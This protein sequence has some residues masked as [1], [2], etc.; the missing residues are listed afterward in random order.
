MKI[1]EVYIYGYGKLS[2]LQLPFSTS[3]QV[4]YG[5]NEAGKSTLMSFIHGILFGFPTKQQSE[6][7]YEPKMGSKYGG[8]MI[9]EIEDHGD[10][11]IERVAG[12][13]VGNVTVKLPDGTIGG[14]EL[15]KNLLKNMNKTMYKNIFSFNVHGLQGVSRLKGDDIGR[16]LLAAGTIGTETIVKSEEQLQKEMD[17]LFKPNGRKPEINEMLQ[18]LKEHEKDF[19]KSMQHNQMYESLQLE[20]QKLLQEINEIQNKISDSYTEVRKLEQLKQDWSLIQERNQILQRIEEIGIPQFPIDGINRMEKIEDQ[21]RIAANQLQILDIRKNQYEKERSQV[22]PNKIMK[23]YE[24]NIQLLIEKWPKIFQWQEEIV[25]GN[26]ELT[27]W[28]D[29]ISILKRQIHFG[30]SDIIELSSLDLSIDMK[31]RIRSSIKNYFYLTSQAAELNKQI[32]IEKR[33]QIELEKQC[34]TIES[35]LL[36]EDEFR[37]LS[38]NQQNYTRLHN[39]YHQLQEQ[40]KLIKPE[41]SSE[42]KENILTYLVLYALFIGFLAWSFIT[43]HYFFL[44]SAFVG[45]VVLSYSIWT[46]KKKGKNNKENQED[47]ILKNA[48]KILEEIKQYKDMGPI[49]E[50]QQML[51]QKWKEL[52]L[53]IENQHVRSEEKIKEHKVWEVEWESVERKLV[54]IKQQLRLHEGFSVEQLPDA[55]DILC[56]LSK[57]VHNRN[58]TEKQINSLLQNVS[59]WE[60]E[61]TKQSNILQLGSLTNEE[62][63]IRLKNM[64]KKEQENRLLY[65]EIDSKLEELENDHL[66]WHKEYTSLE[67]S[68]K[69]LL[70]EAGVENQE[71]FRKKGKVHDEYNSLSRNLTIIEKKVKYE[72]IKAME[73]FPS[74]KELEQELL[75]CQQKL[76][77]TE[78]LLETYQKR[79]LEVQHEI[80]ILED[81]GSYTEKLHEYYRL[82]SVFND[83]AKEWAELAIANQMIKRTMNR[84]KNERFPKVLEKAQE[85]MRI[86]TNGEYVRLI[87]Q[88][89]GQFIVERND[90][91]TFEPDE[92]S[93]ATAEQV[94]VSLRLALVQILQDEFPFPMIIDDGFV[95]FD[96]HRTKRM[97]HILSEISKTTQ[98]IFFTCHQHILE[99]FPKDQILALNEENKYSLAK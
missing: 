81:G 66:K 47:H 37:R 22:E 56:E 3:L 89:A 88:S 16:Y 8:N 70:N 41:K 14:E 40:M 53:Q 39:Q 17:Q 58:S 68:L 94:Y 98:I 1:K 2:S 85:F 11:W 43:K 62:G 97:I 29:Q 72:N 83:K 36:N 86:L 91:I 84:M 27:K 49:Y 60:K 96:K 99:L 74:L 80:S 57:L 38:E 13:A 9:L 15:L 50:E 65:R 30:D 19:K 24:T 23:M 87:F 52:V 95:N 55:F 10:V 90:N 6:L 92:L 26:E 46:N 7:R 61:L 69:S 51:R 82:K 18:K 44:G 63:I 48:E 42:R 35:H 79:K 12:K 5:E 67:T 34:E 77:S 4:I 33:K 54:D 31:E 93:Q 25:R 59:Q 32:E 73:S 20:Y 64:L 76:Q 45:M 75:T 28:N 21:L 71:A 78:N